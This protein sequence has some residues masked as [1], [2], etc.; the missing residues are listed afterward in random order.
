[1]NN[2]IRQDPIRPIDPRQWVAQT[3][4]VL[5]RRRSSFSPLP[6]VNSVLSS[7]SSSSNSPHN[8]SGIKS[9]FYLLSLNTF[10]CS[11]CVLLNRIS[12]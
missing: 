2:N 3:N 5:M 9:K 12:V 7:S 6:V 1:M 10:Y 4:A 8:N 11:F